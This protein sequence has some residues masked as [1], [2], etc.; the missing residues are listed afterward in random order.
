MSWR[1]APRLALLLA[2]LWGCTGVPLRPDG[3][4]GPEECPAGALEAMREMGIKPGDKGSVEADATQNEL[5]P[6]RLMEG[7]VIGFLDEPF[8]RMPERTKLMGRVWTG[9]EDVVIRYYEAQLPDGRRRPVC[10]VAKEGL[11]GLRKREGSVP[12]VAVVEDSLV[13]LRAVDGYR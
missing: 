3:T 12:G 4:P 2:L 6:A 10:M 8:K 11:G 7:P 9:G 1:I 5:R 13:I